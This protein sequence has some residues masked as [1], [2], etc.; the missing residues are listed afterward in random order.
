MNDPQELA[1]AREKEKSEAP[2]TV[3]AF[4]IEPDMLRVADNPVNY[5][6]IVGVAVEKSANQ[7]YSVRLRYVSDK[8]IQVLGRTTKQTELVT[9]PD[10]EK[11]RAEVLLVA[12]R[13]KK[14][15]IADFTGGE[16]LSLHL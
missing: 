11:P 15:N 7:R 13:K 12:L 5:P 14:V 10:L 16:F 3:P 4:V 9:I 6:S 8:D 2:T 1:T